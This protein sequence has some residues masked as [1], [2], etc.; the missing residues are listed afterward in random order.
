MPKWLMYALA[1]APW[2]PILAVWIRRYR[3]GSLRVRFMGL[4]AAIGAFVGLGLPLSLS[5]ILGESAV[6]LGE[7]LLTV[8]IASVLFG[9]A[10]LAWWPILRKG[11]SKKGILW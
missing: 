6:P 1:L 8:T 4:T 10:F 2:I 7:T 9:F 5:T 3:A 11:L